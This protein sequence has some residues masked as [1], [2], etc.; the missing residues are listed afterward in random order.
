MPTCMTVYM[1]D[2]V[3]PVCSAGCHLH[4]VSAGATSGYKENVYSGP[5]FRVAVMVAE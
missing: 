4:V 1:Y 2:C 3:L 5:L